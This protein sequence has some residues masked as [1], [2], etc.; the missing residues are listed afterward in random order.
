MWRQTIEQDKAQT[1]EEGGGGAADWQPA[2]PA[3]LSKCFSMVTSFLSAI[4]SS[5]I[6]PTSSLEHLF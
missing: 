5:Q 3:T 4:L 6:M 1:A 2:H